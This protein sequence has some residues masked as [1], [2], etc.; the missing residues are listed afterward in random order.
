MLKMVAT[1]IA[2]G[3]LLAEPSASATTLGGAGS[4]ETLSQVHAALLEYR[5]GDA[6]G[7]TNVLTSLSYSR[8]EG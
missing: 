6:D 3:I 2:S 4:I 5:T 8:Q 1:V 7:A